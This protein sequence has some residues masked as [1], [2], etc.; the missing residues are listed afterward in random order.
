[1]DQQK[2]ISAGS[3]EEL[4]K[5]DERR[6]RILD[7]TLACYVAH[8]WSGTNMSVIA[9]HA[10]LTRG[11]I[12]YY[13]PTIE[14]IQHASVAH[15]NNEWR[16][17]YFAFIAHESTASD[18]FEDRLE[19]G[20]NALWRLMRDPLNVARQEIAS[21]A[22]SNKELSAILL[23]ET[24]LDEAATLESAKKSY[25]DLARTEERTF[26]RALDYTVIFLEGLSRHQFTDN[27]ESRCRIL[28]DM[29]K[30]QLSAYWQA[31]GIESAK[32]ASVTPSRDARPAPPQLSQTDKDRAL[33]LILKAASILSAP[34]EDP[35]PP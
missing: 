14:A 25:P 8:G 20:V 15:L 11:L 3:S 6:R 7:A 16:K 13:F 22:R 34:A 1:M 32:N 31:H 19:I 12:Q 21:A 35:E 10:R 30:D 28:I 26:R 27:A 29:L 9:R 2:P 5:G 23:R 17:K 4:D 18:R 33:A 24:A